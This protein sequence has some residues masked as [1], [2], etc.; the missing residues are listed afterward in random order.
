MRLAWL[1]VVLLSFGCSVAPLDEDSFEAAKNHC[2]SDSQCGDGSCDTSL[3]ICKANEGQFAKVLFEIT[4]PT[5]AK[6]WSNLGFILPMDVSPSGGALDLSL[7]A[8]S[9]VTGSVS[10]SGYQ[11]QCVYG[12]N[13]E[14]SLTAPVKVTFSSSTRILGLG[15]QEYVT[16]T[17][18]NKKTGQFEFSLSVPPD[19]YDVYI[20][21]IRTRRT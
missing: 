9:K 16:T 11:G 19:E 12:A 6:S 17:S 1:P 20:E 18:F 15:S 2:N 21:S 4:P 13:N 8:V 3:G 14:G 10:P 7:G 5:N